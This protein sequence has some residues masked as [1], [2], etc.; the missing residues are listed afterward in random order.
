MIVR[1]FEVFETRVEVDPDSVKIVNGHANNHRGTTIERV[2]RET[3]LK[4]MGKFDTTAAGQYVFLPEDAPF[5]I[6]VN[7][8]RI[9]KA[10]GAEALAEYIKENGGC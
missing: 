8:E 10:M 9:K 2:I 5:Q 3:A 4:N 1:I 7:C 6:T